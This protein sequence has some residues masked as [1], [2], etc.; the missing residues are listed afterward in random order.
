MKLNFIY[1][2]EIHIQE[3]EYK[4][5]DDDN[6]NNEVKYKLIINQIPH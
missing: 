4:F 3:S 1:R 5:P 6:I 2:N